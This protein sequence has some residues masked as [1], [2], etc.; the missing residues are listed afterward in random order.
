[1]QGPP[2][3]AALLALFLRHTLPSPAPLFRAWPLAALPCGWGTRIAP[4]PAGHNCFVSAS[5]GRVG[6]ALERGTF[7]W[8]KSQGRIG[9][10]QG[11][12]P[13]SDDNGSV[14]RHARTQLQ[15]RVVHF[16]D[17]RVVNHI[18]IRHGSVADLGHLA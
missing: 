10:A 6:G 1:S 17:G 7:G 2:S 11:I 3:I 9:Q 12:A 8:T 5:G 14:S 15:V 16:H 13:L 4:S 18:L